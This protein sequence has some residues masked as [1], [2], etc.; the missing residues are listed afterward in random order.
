MMAHTSHAGGPEFEYCSCMNQ[1]EAEGSMQGGFTFAPGSL[2]YPG[3][4]DFEAR[5]RNC[6]LAYCALQIYNSTSDACCECN[7]TTPLFAD[8]SV[9]R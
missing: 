8:K 4:V 5:V 2:T 6:S 9:C 1:A 3:G 7:C